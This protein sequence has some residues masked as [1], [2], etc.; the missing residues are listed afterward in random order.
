MPWSTRSYGRAGLETLR[1]CLRLRGTRSRTGDSHGAVAIR[2]RRSQLR[3]RLDGCGCRRR[4]RG[5]RR[6]GF[7][8]STT[9]SSAPLL[10]SGQRASHVEPLARQVGCRS[11]GRSMRRRFGELVGS[12][13]GTASGN[14]AP[15]RGAVRST[16]HVSPAPRFRTREDHHF[17][18]VR[19]RRRQRG[20]V[21]R[22]RRGC[23]RQ[24]PHAG[25]VPGRAPRSMSADT[26]QPRTRQ[27]RCRRALPIRSRL[28]VTTL[29]RLERRQN[30]SCPQTLCAEATSTSRSRHS[31]SSAAYERGCEQST[32]VQPVQG[33]G[34]NA[35][36]LLRSWRRR[37]V[38][39]SGRRRE[40]G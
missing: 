33:A 39:Q 36:L 13:S 16:L 28:P 6:I 12:R 11:R 27:F 2:Y 29:E 40:R 30:R 4:R 38:R 18:G 10:R 26:A 9:P 3:S 23:T 22:S 32:T 34:T 25:R 24:L 31:A 35:H 15:L 5:H 19:R 20:R 8:R 7:A 21:R 1:R 17:E 37:P 14:L